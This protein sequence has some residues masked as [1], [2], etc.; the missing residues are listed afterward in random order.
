MTSNS[1]PSGVCSASSE[2]NGTYAAWKAADDVIVGDNTWRSASG[3]P[4][5]WQ[6]Q[7]ASAT[8]INQYTL[9]SRPGNYL[10]T[11]TSWN[12][13]GSNN[14]TDWTT[15]DTRRTGSFTSDDKQTFNFSNT[16]AYSYYRLNVTGSNGSSYVA[17]GEIELIGSTKTSQA[18]VNADGLIIGGDTTATG[19]IV[20]K[21]TGE[22]VFNEQ[23]A[24]VDFRIESNGDA[25]C[26]YVDAGNDKVGIGTATPAAKLDVAGDIFPTTDNSYYLGK[27]DDDT[28]K[29]WK[30]VI[31]KDTTNGKYYR[32]EIINGVITATD[33]TD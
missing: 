26:F 24:D 4:Q 8:T 12:L 28:P 10:W 31:L 20:L 2:Y 6:Y 9:R 3:P 22:T 17:I 14:G 19:D 33:L 27:N 32:I 23:S 18:V 11:P 30:G 13:C 29:A 7:A 25:N 1:T 15:L 5:W 21:F 16:T